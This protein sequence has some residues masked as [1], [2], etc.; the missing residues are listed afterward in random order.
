MKPGLALVTGASAGIG[1]EFARIHAAAGGDL[2]LTAR[3]QDVLETL[4]AELRAKYAVSVHVMPSDLAA[5]GGAQALYDEIAA[6]KLDVELLVNN[7][8][9]GGRGAFAEQDLASALAMIELNIKALVTLTR[10]IGAD[11]VQRGRGRILN[12]GS[13]AGMVPGPLQAVYFASKAFVNSFSQALAE[14]MRG[15]GVSVTLLAPGPV[16]TEF[17]KVAGLEGTRAF[18]TG[19]ADAASVARAGYEAAMGGDLLTVN[20]KRLGLLLRWAV[21]ALPR[22]AVLRVM[23][24]I[25]EAR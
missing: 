22:Q 5:P 25:G 16:D 17:A 13:T 1:R 12:V 14:E 23:R 21:P 18:E 10:L 7:A 4:A 11:M 20:D 19:V 24:R 6:H 8:G 2:V 9:F 3:R 15:E